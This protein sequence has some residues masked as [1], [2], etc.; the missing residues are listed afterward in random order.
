M[1][2]K[3]IFFCLKDAVA[4]RTPKEKIGKKKKRVDEQEQA[5]A[6]KLPEVDLSRVGSAIEDGSDSGEE[7]RPLSGKAARFFDQ[8]L[9]RDIEDVLVSG[10]E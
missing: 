3:L 1:N 4:K 6:G 2:L 5:A 10:V 9:F 7:V 8:D